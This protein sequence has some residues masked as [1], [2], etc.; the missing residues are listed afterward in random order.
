MGSS[1]GTK[2][3]MGKRHQ[4]LAKARHR[5]Q[6]LIALTGRRPTKG[7]PD[8]LEF[9]PAA[10]D[11][12]EYTDLSTRVSTY[13]AD[14]GLPLYLPGPR[15]KIDPSLVPW[16]DRSLVRDPGWIA[17]RPAGRRHIVVHR[18]T[19]EAARMLVSSRDPVTVVDERLHAFSEM[20]YFFLRNATSWPT[21]APAETALQRLRAAVGPGRSAFILATG[22]AALTVDLPAVTADVRITCNSAVR[23]IDRIREYRPNII[24]CTDPVF[25]FG[26]SRYATGFRRDL[27]RAVEEV[28]AVVLSGHDCVGPLLGL[29]PELRDRLVVLPTQQSGPW[30]WP[31]DRNP[32]VRLGLSVLINLMLPV[33][34][35]LADDIS[36]AGADGRHPAEKY[37]WSHNPQLQ[38]SD[39]LMQTVFDAHPSFFRD[40]DYA[41]YYDLHSEQVEALMKTGERAGKVFH[42]AA[43]SWIPALRKRG[44]PEPVPA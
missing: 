17:E 7:F 19:H 23:D 13:L 15:F 31:T 14:A 18:L 41:D 20:Q 33:A 34:M 37:F 24:A 39:E 35:M 16:F 42:A 6:R 10:R 43:P 2:A 25:H 30:R 9:A 29:A 27:V 8:Y 12:A 11:A 22:P 36:I 26:P 28:D 5:T 3:A 44:A 4:R 32:T 21:Y 38:Y 1:H 40:R